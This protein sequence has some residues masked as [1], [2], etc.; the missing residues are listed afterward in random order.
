MAYWLALHSWTDEASQDD[1]DAL[2]PLL[3]RAAELGRDDPGLLVMCAATMVQMGGV[4]E[5]EPWVQRADELADEAFP[6]GNELVWLKGC[7]LWARGDDAHAEPLLRAAFFADPEKQSGVPLAD[8]YIGLND[9]E[10]ASAIVE[11]SLRRGGRHPVLQ[12][13]RNWLASA[14]RPTS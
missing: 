5:I 3:R 9:L 7:V 1:V 4:D 14:Q 11:E 12:E 13:M 10:R 6:L 8:V 2:K